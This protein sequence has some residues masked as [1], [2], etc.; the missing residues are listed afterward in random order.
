MKQYNDFSKIIHK[1]GYIFIV[2]FAVV[3]FL[4]ASFSNILGIIGG[5]A[6]LW[7]IYFFRNPDRIV[8]INEKL[9]ISPADG[10]VQAIVES[11]AP[12]E[13]GLGDEEMI[14]VSIFLNIFNVHVNRIPIS[15]KVLALHYNPGRFFNASLDKASIHNERQSILLET[16]TGHKIVCIQIAGL[17]ARR[18]VCDLEEG[19]EVN[20]GDRYGII[21][22]G[23][24]VDLYLPLKTAILVSEGQTCIGG[25]TIIANLDIKKT[26]EPIFVKK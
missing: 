12:A 5:V 15:S 1:E 25:E 24:R 21:R 6:T 19:A 3:T 8:P 17:I 18:I 4:L 20:A 26:L 16:K 2:S 23:S 9:V 14:R 7:C 10:I 22:F 13:L 11:K